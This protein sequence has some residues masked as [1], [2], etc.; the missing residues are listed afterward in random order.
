MATKEKAPK[1]TSILELV[2]FTLQQQFDFTKGSLVPGAKLKIKLFGK[3][4]WIRI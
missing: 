4:I 2:K 3:S 1:P